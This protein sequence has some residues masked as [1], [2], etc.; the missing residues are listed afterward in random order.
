MLSRRNFIAAGLLL[1]APRVPQIKLQRI[2]PDWI[3]V[4]ALRPMGPQMGSTVIADI[5]SR[6]SASD[7][8]TYHD[9]SPM[10][11]AHEATHGLQGRLRERLGRCAFYPLGGYAVGLI[12]PPGTL[13]QIAQAQPG[14]LRGSMYRDYLRNPQVTRY[15][16]QNPLY[17]LDEWTAYTNGSAC[18]LELARAGRTP[19]DHITNLE[20]AFEFGL[21]STVMASLTPSNYDR[22]PLVAYLRWNWVRLRKIQQQSSPYPSLR[23]ELAEALLERLRTG[24]DAAVARLRYWCRDTFGEPWLTTILDFQ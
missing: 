4:P 24:T 14:P 18:G 20:Q 22:E 19:T 9:S 23:A 3:Q 1:L 6:L 7:S 16:E 13:Q 12:E 10:T 8:R 5:D 21:I 17:V 11:W 15:W 2:S